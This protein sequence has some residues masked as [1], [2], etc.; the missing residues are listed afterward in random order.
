MEKKV[1]RVTTHVRGLRGCSQSFLAEASDGEIYVVKPGN[2]EL[3]ENLLFNELAGTELYRACGLAVAP[4]RP[5]LVTEDF[6]HRNPQCNIWRETTK[7][8]ESL[9]SGIFFGSSYLGCKPNTVFEILPGGYFSRVC[10]AADFWLAWL[11]DICASHTDNR[12]ALFVERETRELDPIFI[13]FS[14]MF[15]GPKGS[16]EKHFEATRYLD[17]RIYPPLTP[18]TLQ[19]IRRRAA[20]LNGEKL[21]RQI[22]KAPDKWITPRGVLN[23]FKCLN[24]LADS[25]FVEKCLDMMATSIQPQDDISPASIRHSRNPFLSSGLQVKRFPRAI[26]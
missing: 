11:V 16:E 4:W 23:L 6:L 25:E 17:T 18:R 21:C 7:S 8:R 24:R 13:D 9:P 10:D 26:A 12:Q 19:S 14:H 2:G 20:D 3:G 1:A 22:G 15:G 5:V